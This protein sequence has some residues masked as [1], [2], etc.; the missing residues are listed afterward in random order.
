MS[1]RD[2]AHPLV[3]DFDE[4]LFAGTAEWYA[5]H[6]PPYPSELLDELVYTAPGQRGEGRMLVDVACGPGTICLALH[7]HFDAVLA[8]DLEPDMIARGRALAREAGAGNIEWTV[9]RAE[10]LDLPAATVDL[11][12]IGNAFHRLDRPL[13]AS[14]ALAWLRAGGVFADVGGGTRM[15]SGNEPWQ[16]VVSDVYRRWIARA[17]H[18]PVSRSPKDARLAT[19]EEVLRDAGFVDV[20]KRVVEVPH[21][22]TADDVVGYLFSTS[23]ASR[24]IFGGLADGFA[25]AV[26]AAL[27]AHDPRGQ[28]RE[29]LS[30]YV[31]T[32]R[33]PS[34]DVR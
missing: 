31:V 34:T 16:R 10:D 33:R 4:D 20:S 5:R 15:T 11:V 9:G 8:V 7:R 17:P 19:T 28:F 12:T 24:A 32:G 2:H 29:A 22:W 1:D 23:Y 13:V 3:P 14:R 27:L 6:R 25:E 26:R 21:V 18:R 30:A